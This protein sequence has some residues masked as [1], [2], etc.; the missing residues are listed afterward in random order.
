MVYGS[1]HQLYR[2]DHKLVAVGVVDILPNCLSAKYFYYDPDY[3]FLE[4]GKVQ[5]TNRQADGRNYKFL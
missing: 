4:L 3:K 1:Y 2:I 5:Q